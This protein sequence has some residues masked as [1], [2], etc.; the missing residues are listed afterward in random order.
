MKKI[1]ASL[2]IVT[3]LLFAL[4]YGDGPSKEFQ[5]AKEISISMGKVIRGVH[6][7]SVVRIERGVTVSYRVAYDPESDYIAG[8]MIEGQ[9]MFIITYNG[10]PGV[11]LAQLIDME[12]NV[13]VKQ[14]VA[15]EEKASKF[16]SNVLKHFRNQ[17]ISF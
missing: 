5:T 4:A 10:E 9:V 16:M 3:L 2:F 17:D 12:R 11:Y 8:A 7:A 1:L 6:V 15:E 14:E 13:I